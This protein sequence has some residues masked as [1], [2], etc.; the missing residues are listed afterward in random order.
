MITANL[1]SL[2]DW[3]MP[4]EMTKEDIYIEGLPRLAGHKKNHLCLVAKHHI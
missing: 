3:E 2:F 1:L 4:E